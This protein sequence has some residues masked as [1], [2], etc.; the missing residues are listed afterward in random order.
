MSA[1]GGGILVLVAMIY[2]VPVA[3][4][5]VGWLFGSGLGWV[6]KNDVVTGPIQTDR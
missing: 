1:I 4:I 5:F 3:A 6:V 2:G